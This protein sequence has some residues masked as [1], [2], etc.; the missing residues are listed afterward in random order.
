MRKAAIACAAAGVILLAGA[1]LLAFWITPAFIARLPGDS[2]TTRT[3]TGQIRSLVN[4][5]ALLQG[6]F[7]GAVRTGLPETIR[8]QDQ[9][10]ATSGN[11]ALVKDSGTATAGG[12]PIAG[13]TEQ[14]AVDRTSLAATA[15]HPADWKV[16]SAKGLTFNWPIPTQQRSYTGWEPFTQTTTTL[17]YVRQE[18]RGG[19]N[20]YV[21]QAT[22]PPT[23]I[24]N[25]QV[26]HLLPTSMPVPA[27]QG[28]AKAGLIPPALLA[29]LGTVLPHATTVPLGYTY[30][31]AATYWV[32]PNTGIV[33]DLTTSQQQRAGLAAAGNVIPVLPVLVDSYH[34]SPAS[35]Q[36]AAN[37]ARSGANTIAWA[38][39]WVPII[40]AAVGFAL[41]VLALVLWVR[42][43][44]QPV[45][46]A[47]PRVHA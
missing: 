9:V 4:P 15:S 12:Q 46:P 40:C 34:G 39:M 41:L 36:A 31:A 38:G 13:I 10:V 44:P 29:K 45:A 11:T 20:T 18:K 42:G 27:L 30:Q 33:V 5:A 25:P 14:Y 24:R 7:T 1:G 17:K 16:T 43:R 6:K 3:Y 35:V 23:P 21:F 47:R 28:A 32:D 8:R 2:N 19:I 37:D 22:V 26:L